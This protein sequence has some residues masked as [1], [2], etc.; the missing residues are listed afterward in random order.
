M[1]L[2]APAHAHGSYDDSLRSI[3]A[4]RVT[5]ATRWSAGGERQAVEARAAKTILRNVRTLVSHWLGT[6]WA[7]GTP[8]AT[9][10]GQGKINCGTFVGRVLRDA[11]FRLPVKRL[12]RQPA[13]LI[14][15]TFVGGRRV[16]RFSNAPM[17]SFLRQVRAMGPGLYIIGLDFHVGFL[18]HTG[19]ELRFVHASYET[20]TVVDERAA[21][22]MPIQSSKYRVVGKLLSRRN[23]VDW[24][25]GRSIQ[26]KG[27]W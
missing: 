11:G 1:G 25:G 5:L 10:P 9:R 21:T 3:A 24:L 8:Q 15:K 16:R 2:G 26:V 17:A 6:R 20:H 27:K 4:E 23:V 22:A 13:E 7:L 18:I 19:A 14:I 12:Q